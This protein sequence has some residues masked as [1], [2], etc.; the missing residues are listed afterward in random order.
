M[1]TDDF[2]FLLAQRISADWPWGL[3]SGPDLAFYALRITR[4]QTLRGCRTEP[5]LCG[6]LRGQRVI[7]ALE[8]Q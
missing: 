5:V 1:F 6:T 2:R 7:D 4:V 8:L 3:G